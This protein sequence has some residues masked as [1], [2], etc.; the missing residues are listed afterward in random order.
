V[1]TEYTLGN[2]KTIGTYVLVK[3]FEKDQSEQVSKAFVSDGYVD[4]I[5]SN[6]K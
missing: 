4:T 2:N 5:L 3:I 1:I 6:I